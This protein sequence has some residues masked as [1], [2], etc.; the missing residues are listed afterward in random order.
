[1]PR[2][3]QKR[4]TAAVLHRRPRWDNVMSMKTHIRMI[5]SSFAIG[6]AILASAA[7]RAEN[8]PQWRG[9]DGNSQ[10]RET[11]L[12]VIW[13]ESQGVIWKTPLPEYGDSTPAIW[14]DAIFLTSH[15]DEDLLLLRINKQ[16]GKIE[17]TQTVGQGTARHVPIAKKSDQERREQK[18]H[19][20][21]NLASPSPVTD[22]KTVVVHFGNG[23]F[24]AY[25]FAGER[26][27]QRN[28]QDDYG[29]Y[30]VWWGHANSPVLFGNTVISVCMQDNLADFAEKPTES[31]VVAHDLATGKEVWRTLRMTG[32]KAEEADAYTTPV[33]HKS[34]DKTELLVMGGNQVDAYDPAT[35]KQ[36]WFLPN[37]VGGRTVHSPTAWNDLLF[38]TQ[39]KSG[40]MLAVKLDDHKGELS[41]ETGI[42]WRDPTGTPDTC[43]P[44][45]SGEYLF[46]LTDGG[47]AKCFE[48]RTGQLKWKERVKSDYR[49][50]PV[51]AEG[52]IYFLNMH[53]L[54]TVISANDRF[55]K[56]SENQLDD[57]TIASPSISD[58]KI[59]IRGKKTLYCLGKP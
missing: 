7:A 57:D 58:G 39:G 26:L 45:V 33:L 48:A 37:I 3:P 49:A 54:C 43:C 56:L 5:V 21:H 18:F 1:M 52:R 24:A 30:T 41:R 4:R 13:N 8:W 17:W 47:I 16:S 32:A 29:T 10:S 42:A 23:E 25:N 34:G 40:P 31:Y 9:P 59:F 22:G 19:N 15:K 11:D 14:G 6:V 53:G 27:W 2:F 55:E 50:S 35:G 36:L 46:A 38:V 20:V 28:L 44:V 12:P 51:A